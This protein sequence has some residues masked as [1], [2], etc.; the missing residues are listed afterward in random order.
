MHRGRYIARFTNRTNKYLAEV[1]YTYSICRETLKC[2][3]GDLCSKEQ[4]RA[5]GHITIIPQCCIDWLGNVHFF[6]QAIMFTSNLRQ[7]VQPPKIM[8]NQR[9]NAFLLFL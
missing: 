2:A 7:S 8:P 4:I 1:S 5:D 9:K 6:W 3:L